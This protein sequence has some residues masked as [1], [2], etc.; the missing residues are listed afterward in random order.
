M[1]SGAWDDNGI[2]QQALRY[3]RAD[4]PSLY[5]ITDV[6]MCEYTS[7]GH[8]GILS[9]DYVDND[10]TLDVLAK[11]ALSY[12]KA[13]AD[14]VAS[15]DM[16]DYHN[17]KEAIREATLDI[18]EGADIIM[19]KPGLVYLDVLMELARFLAYFLEKHNL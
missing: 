6:C 10:K 9:G 15:S 2:V 5:Y 16:M 7:H 17:L 4:F 1:G 12:V 19:M 14:M 3:G 18:E 13:G 8:C 11:T